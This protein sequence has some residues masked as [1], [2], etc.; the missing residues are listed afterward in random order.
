MSGLKPFVRCDK[1]NLSLV[2]DLRRGFAEL[3]WIGQTLA[4]GEDLQAMSDAQM[5]GS[6]QSQPD[7]P[8]PSSI[9]P[10]SGWGFFGT[11]AITLSQSGKAM[12]S[13]FVLASVVELSSGASFTFNDAAS[14]ATAE[15]CWTIMQS[16]VIKSEICLT[17]N[18]DKP[19]GLGSLASLALPLPSWARFAVRYSGRWAAEMDTRRFEISSNGL[20]ATSN[21]G[22][23]GFGGG[24]WIR[25]ES[26]DASEDHGH[27]IAAHLAWSGDH[28]L[29]VER[30]ADGEAMLMM[31]A[32][33]EVGEITLEPGQIWRAPDCIIAVSNS[34]IGTARHAFHS[35]A[36]AE[37]LPKAGASPRKVHLNTWE[38]LGFGIDQRK[39]ND[40]VDAAAAL[41]VERFLL[42]DGWF[43]GRRNDRSSLGDWVPDWGI[44]PKGLTPLIEHVELLGMDFGLWVEPEMISPD[45]DLYR[46]HPDW[47]IHVAG[48]DRLTQRNQ[49]V[50][51]L[52]R[53][54]V[55]DHL[56][57]SLDTL[58]RDNRIAYL[59]WDHNRDL[60]PLVG[61]GHAQ[62]TALYALLDR[63]RLAHPNVEIETC[64]SGGGRVDFAILKRC[65]R[66][67]ASDNND[68]IDRLHIN[69]GWFDFF[70]LRAVG[71]HVGPSPNPITGRQI[72]MDFRAKVAMFGHMGVEA[73]PGA[74]SEDER[75]ILK[76]H[77]AIYKQWRD[78]LHSGKVSVVGCDDPGVYG[79]LVCVE[80]RGIALVAQKLH[81]RSFE[82]APVRLGGLVPHKRY[83]IRLLDPW[84]KMAARRLANP[85]RWRD[86]MVLSG[87][88]LAEAGLALPLNLPETAWLIALELAD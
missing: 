81:A 13:R 64:A 17:N 77:I 69:A 71:N 14:G 44:F 72:S 60:F 41:G 59:K 6:H 35:H 57:A 66:F 28:Q 48:Q 3:A 34:G 7:M 15:V 38:A 46:D 63:L 25:I 54:Q 42:D 22:R 70:P 84:P 23:P 53:P 62:V 65:A 68:A 49:L 75:E 10:R 85:E 86:G 52:T 11:P 1:G 16:G 31:A 19:F 5:R 9:L 74:M 2:F 30:N 26:A 78:V 4:S 33:L 29:L 82:V 73:N 27:V 36:I 76:A 58:L 50:L 87:K 12:P 18:G 67:W 40:L 47:C 32:R 79:W 20:S 83:K 55:T 43:K 8:E 61:K 37:T 21:G 24:N 80:N 45:S 51:D 56:F 39:L 88:V